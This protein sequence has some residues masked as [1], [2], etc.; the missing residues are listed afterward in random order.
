MKKRTF[1]NILL[2]SDMDGTLLDSDS[3]ISEQNREAIHRFVDAGG[4]FTLATGRTDRSVSHYLDQLPINVPAITFNG[5]VIYDFAKDD[6]LW[7]D[8]L[9]EN[10]Y[11]V[12]KDVMVEFP[13]LAVSIFHKK[14]V[15]TPA[16]NIETFKHAKREWFEP[17]QVPLGE[18]PFPWYKII[19]AWDPPKLPAVDAYLA[20]R[21]EIF[22][23]VYSEPQ[24][25]ELLKITTSKG[26]ALKKLLEIINNPDLR[27][28]A[29]GDNMNDLEMLKEAG[30]GVAVGNAASKLKEKADI[31][32][33]DHNM[34]A[35][36]QVIDWIECGHI[37]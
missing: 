21:K 33:V 22:H 19:L 2:I 20:A 10:I 25:L 5:A 27:V 9:P 37:A 6:V 16:V 18:V 32:S 13:E 29:I 31:C 3:R 4:L 24:F 30:V 15:F 36:S 14:Q 12:V 35:V 23:K 28:I 17:I 7:Y 34:H 1:E 11:D 8:C 26:H